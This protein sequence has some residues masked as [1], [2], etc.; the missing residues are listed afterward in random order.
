MS[1]W[2]SVKEKRPPFCETVILSYDLDDDGFE[3]RVT[4]GWVESEDDDEDPWFVQCE[5]NNYLERV[6]HWQPLPKAPK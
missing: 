2:I 5:S 1:G 6:T 4:C 3:S